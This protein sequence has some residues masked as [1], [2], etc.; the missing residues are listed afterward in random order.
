METSEKDIYAAGDCVQTNHIVTEDP[1]YIP[2]ALTANKMGML[3]GKNMVGEKKPFEGVAG[4]SITKAFDLE[5]GRTGLNTEEAEEKGYD[6]VKS[7]IKTRSK[8]G[9]YPGS[10]RIRVTYIMEEDTGKLLGSQMVGDGVGKRIDVV[11]TAL[12]AGYTIDDMLD[13]D[14]SYAPPF[15]PVWDPVL[16]AA[17]VASKKI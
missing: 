7:T 3:A 1:T 12:D 15:S 17:R 9:Y 14:L 2:L 16:K 5:I 11:A 6:V 8:A 13:L 4:T 10:K